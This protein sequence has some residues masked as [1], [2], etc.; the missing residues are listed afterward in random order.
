[1]KE[2]S[3]SSCGSTSL[4]IYDDY[5]ICNHCHSKFA[6]A[7][8]N[9]ETEKLPLLSLRV[10]IFIAF[11]I[12]NILILNYYF[13]IYKQDIVEKPKVVK[14]EFWNNVYNYRYMSRI[15]S[16]QKTDSELSSE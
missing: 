10:K 3:C 6:I 4:S 16:L 12:V 14:M 15:A 2:P 7:K 9:K 5:Y 13:F 11:I 8:E 1:M